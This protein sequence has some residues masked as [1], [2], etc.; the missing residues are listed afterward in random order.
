MHFALGV[1]ATLGWFSFPIVPRISPLTFDIAVAAE[2]LPKGPGFHP[3]DSRNSD[4]VTILPQPGVLDTCKSIESKTLKSWSENA[5][6]DW[7]VER[8]EPL[9]SFI[10]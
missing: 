1:V 3:L 6:G 9:A 4:N 7:F 5:M 10:C 2:A 8:Y